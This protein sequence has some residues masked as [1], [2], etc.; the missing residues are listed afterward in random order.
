MTEEVHNKFSV[1]IDL[2]SKDVNLVANKHFPT[3]TE[4]EYKT[5]LVALFNVKETVIKEAKKR[6][7]HWKRRP[8]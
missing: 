2:E 7:P 1:T 4:D 3:F 8:K 5:I 6:F